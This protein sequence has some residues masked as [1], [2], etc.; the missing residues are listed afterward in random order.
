MKRRIV[1]SHERATA[2]KRGGARA[3]SRSTSRWRRSVFAKSLI[4]GSIRARRVRCMSSR[5]WALLRISS[6]TASRFRVT[7]SSAACVFRCL[8]FRLGARAGCERRKRA[9][10]DRKQPGSGLHLRGDAGDRKHA[11]RR[12]PRQ[13]ARQPVPHR[14]PQRAVGCPSYCNELPRDVVVSGGITA[15]DRRLMK[16]RAQTERQRWSLRRP[17]A[18]L[19]WKRMAESTKQ[20]IRGSPVAPGSTRLS[21]NGR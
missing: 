16:S 12:H 11:D 6:E 19:D 13:Q 8:Q 20:P 21:Y 18:P 1:H 15:S 10:A 14:R 5:A 3:L 2:P 17:P 4:R 9:S 7:K